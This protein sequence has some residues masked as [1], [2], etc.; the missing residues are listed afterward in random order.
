MSALKAIII[1]D[2]Q[3]CIDTLQWLVD[4]YVPNVDVVDVFTSPKKALESLLTTTPDL[5]FLDIEMPEFSGFEFLKKV[6][7]KDF[8]VIFTTAYD[9]FA[10]KAFKASAIDYLLKPIGKND[11][12]NAVT[13]VEKKKKPNI[14]PQQMEILYNAIA[15]KKTLKERI[16]IPTQDGIRFIKIKDILY[17]VSDS[18]YTF[19]HLQDSKK[20]LV[21]KTLK[22]IESILSENGFL[23]IHHSHM[24]NT[25]R[26]DR[27]I[28]GDGGYVVMDDKKSLSVSRSRKEALLAIFDN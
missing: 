23:R 5:I 27:Y 20:H 28:R 14:L 3:H 21:S 11:I 7:E 16:A 19:I 12:I 9:E 17:C 26:I 1:D 8:E 6:P 18:N 25:Q 2:E 10:I 24:I 22:E 13:K 15:E 4:K